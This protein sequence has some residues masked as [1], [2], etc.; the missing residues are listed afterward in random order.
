MNRGILMKAARELWPT[1]LLLS[2]ALMVAQAILAF[3]LPT[4][5]REIT[6][7]MFRIPLIQNLIRGLL[8]VD[9]RGALGPEMFESI[10]W[11]HPVVLAITW[12]HAIIICTRM[13]AGEVDRG[14]ID[15][16]L[17]LPVSRWNLSVSETIAWLTSGIV[18][19]GAGLAGNAIG[20]SFL[21]PQFYQPPTHRL[22]IVLVNFFA[23][24]CAVGAMAWL[25]SAMSDRRG[26]AI[27]AAF[28]VVLGSFLLNYLAQF[29]EPAELLSFLG[30]LQYYRPLIILREGAWQLKDLLVLGGLALVLWTSAG[31][32]FSRRDLATI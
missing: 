11:V 19:L 25:F 6:S 9:A 5:Q 18:L 16:L 21:P 8:G 30:L 17:G 20:H 7:Q 3:V 32:A 13:P 22:L 24:Y 10:G 26:R 1:T 2:I 28:G 27:G 12:A 31:I 15:V 4:F 29:W 14:T 23:L